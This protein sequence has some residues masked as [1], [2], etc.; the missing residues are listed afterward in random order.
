MHVEDVARGLLLA[1]Q[2]GRPGERYILGGER[3]VLREYFS[4]I[5]DE[6]GRPRRC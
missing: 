2:R 4:L 3:V 6:C 5:A 1:M